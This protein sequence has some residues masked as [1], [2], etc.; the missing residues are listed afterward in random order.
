MKNSSGKVLT[1]FLVIIAI[2]LISLTAIS[3]FFFQKEIEKRKMADA[4]VEQLQANEAKLEE[5]LKEVKKMSFLLQEKN[6]EA[7]DRIN[8]LLDELELQEGIREKLKADNVALK[9]QT[10]KALKE[11]QEFQEKLAGDIKGSEQRISDLE[12]KL[13]AALQSK[14]DIEKLY[15]GLQEQYTQLKEEAKLTVQPQASSQTQDKGVELDAIV[16]TPGKEA[17]VSHEE[18]TTDEISTLPSDTSDGRILSVDTDTEFVIVNLGE[19]DGIKRNMF[20]SVYRG[21]E[22]LGDIQI[23]RVQPEM[24]AADFVPPFSS[25]S[26]RKNDQVV[27]KK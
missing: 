24:S 5:S 14:E 7:D 25:R 23:T 4:R 19:K 9:Q 8:N 16:V 6:K 15:K 18:K 26:V 11:R 17:Q 3:I 13:K 1:I 21:K 10:E 12:T 22:Y 27:A 20:L 2:L